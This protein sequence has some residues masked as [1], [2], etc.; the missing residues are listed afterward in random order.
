[1]TINTNLDKIKKYLATEVTTY[2]LLLDG[3]WGSGKTH[4]ISNTLAEELSNTKFSIRYISL[5]GV[6]DLNELK[7]KIFFELM[8]KRGK[9]VNQSATFAGRLLE[10]VAPL[11]GVLQVG[12]N[13]IEQIRSVEKSF[14]KKKLA[15]CFFCFDDFERISENLPMEEVFG[16]INTNFVEFDNV[17]VLIVV[18]SNKIEGKQREKFNKGKEKIIGRTL[19][20][21]TLM[22][23]DILEEFSS[24]YSKDSL[25]SKWLE[26]HEKREDIASVIKDFEIINLRQIK[27][28][29]GIFDEILT[30]TAGYLNTLEESIRNKLVSIMFNNL[31]IVY[32]DREGDNPQVNYKR[33]MERHYI[34]KEKLSI[35][36]DNP[37]YKRRADEE[38]SFFEKFHEKN[39]YVKENLYYFDLITEYVINARIDSSTAENELDTYVK[40]YL[41]EDPMMNSYEKIKNFRQ[42]EKEDFDRE[43]RTF[44]HLL[45]N[46]TSLSV[47][48]YKNLYYILNLLSNNEFN[49][50]SNWKNVVF[51][52]F[53]RRTEE[54]EFV[55]DDTSDAFAWN[56]FGGKF[57]EMEGIYKKAKDKNVK[58]R[59]MCKVEDWFKN[60]YF[61]KE[62]EYDL[63]AK[64]FTRAN[65]LGVVDKY[66]M[67]SNESIL[68]LKD[69]IKRVYR[70]LK[71]NDR[72]SPQKKD[73][74]IFCTSILT[75]ELNHKNDYIQQHN[76]RELVDLLKDAI[77]EKEEI[78]EECN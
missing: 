58:E 67:K 6:S 59:E 28:I 49:L 47:S 69:A 36:N 40:R 23:T 4:F 26:P 19:K 20:Q 12:S 31:L 43:I 56:D 66:V 24:P 62:N 32:I 60:N 27:N 21:E 41:K 76:I 35:Y 10:S 42:L 16:F 25:L 3:E 72:I 8:S 17:K 73:I 57:S 68:L 11:N 63:T 55:M 30:E 7:K 15:N 39:S 38:K 50:P 53:V 29:I 74:E 46:E 70:P 34:I 65:E 54:F 45:P 2:A 61:C 78:S 1:M 64:L 52:S 14:N 13:F 22:M 37:E 75:S 77:K 44:F 33:I 48:D 51:D 71:N 5:N 18:N 9:K